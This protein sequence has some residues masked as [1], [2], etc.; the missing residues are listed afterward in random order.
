MN[1]SLVKNLKIFTIIILAMVISIA[2][3]L[4]YK[5]NSIFKEAWANVIPHSINWNDY[6][7]DFQV[8]AKSE[9]KRTDY[10][11]DFSRMTL[12]R[13]LNGKISKVL[14]GIFLAT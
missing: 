1:R 14:N 3:Y 13:Y 12:E 8:V 7:K 2:S 4:T 11:M 5:T 6:S 9:F 10:R